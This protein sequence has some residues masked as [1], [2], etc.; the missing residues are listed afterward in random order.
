MSGYE[1]IWKRHDLVIEFSIFFTK[2]LKYNVKIWWLHYIMLLCSGQYKT[3]TQ[4]KAM[5]II[6]AVN[7]LL[8]SESHCKC[9]K[10]YFY[11][12][13][14]L[15]TTWPFTSYQY[16]NVIVMFTLLYWTSLQTL[17]SSDVFCNKL[18]ISC[19]AK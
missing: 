7:C 11:Q 9:S 18:W 10:S 3:G 14:L 2:C 12:T 19:T 16:N 6:V 5:H 15:H 4:Y 1:Q 17:T 8:H 13:S